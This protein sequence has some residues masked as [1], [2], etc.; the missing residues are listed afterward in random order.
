VVDLFEVE[1]SGNC[2]NCLFMGKCLKISIRLT[3]ITLCK[4][5]LQQGIDMIDNPFEFQTDDPN[6][7]AEFWSNNIWCPV[8]NSSNVTRT[9]DGHGHTCNSCGYRWG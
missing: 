3:D 7:I 4:K 8:C 9:L 5:C 1:E 2:A 6:D